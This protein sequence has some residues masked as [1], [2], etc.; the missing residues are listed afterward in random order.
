LKTS[1]ICLALV[2]DLVEQEGWAINKCLLSNEVVSSL[3][4]TITNLYENNQLNAAKLGQAALYEKSVRGDL[5]QWIDVENDLSDALLSYTN[6]LSEFQI[7]LNRELQL[8]IKEFEVHYTLYPKGRYYLCHVDQFMQKKNRCVSFVLYLNS[9][10]QATDGGIL[11]L[12]NKNNTQKLIEVAPEANSFICFFS[13]LPHEISVT[14]RERLS[15]T[16]WFKRY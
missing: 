6:F 11:T 13:D 2:N 12:Y 10:W 14:H 9:A 16:G 1:D 5:I 7:V 3:N 8:G 4:N 15:I